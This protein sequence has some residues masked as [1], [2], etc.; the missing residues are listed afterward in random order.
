MSV[1]ANDEVKIPQARGSLLIL[2][3][4]ILVSAS[5]DILLI[6]AGLQNM[7][8]V[9]ILLA[10]HMG[11]APFIW[12][13]TRNCDPT[14]SAMAVIANMT[15][16]PVGALGTLL[17]A[18]SLASGRKSSASSLAE[19]HN[20]LAKPSEVDL[21]QQLS[22]AIREGRMLEPGEVCPAS[23]QEVSQ[24]GSVAQRQTMLG[25][26]SQRFDPAFSETLRQELRSEQAA[27]RVS[28]AAV[29]SKLRDK[30]RQQMGAG[31]PLPDVLTPSDAY[32]RGIALARGVKSGLLDPADLVAA[33]VQSLDLL[34]RARPRATEADELEEVICTLLFDAERYQALQERLDAIDP[35]HSAILRSLH[36]RLLM[37]AGRVTEAAEMIRRRQGNSVRLNLSRRADGEHALLSLRHGDGQ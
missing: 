29:F 19:W 12:L 10:L 8:P 24:Y 5:A 31:K 22:Q 30:N 9:P 17:L 3:G 1:Q 4:V 37:K 15:L 36:A 2:V 11:I 32:E 14:L 18:V 35:G 6:A 20:K 21:A 7:L 23:F 26:V 13:A 28:A 33:R 16:G 34:M 27:V 25:L